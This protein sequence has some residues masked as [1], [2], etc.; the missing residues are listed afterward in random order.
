MAEKKGR[1][2]EGTEEGEEIEEYKKFRRKVGTM[3]VKKITRGKRRKETREGRTNPGGQIDASR[4]RL[5]HSHMRGRILR[6]G[7]KRIREIEEGE[8]EE[9]E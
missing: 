5:R 7:G 9:E 6:R 3:M 4:N 8:E 2:E 1:K